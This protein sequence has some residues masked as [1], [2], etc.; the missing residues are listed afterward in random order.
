MLIK[1]EIP[2]VKIEDTKCDVT[3]E[4][5]TFSYKEFAL[6]FKFRLPVNDKSIKY[7]VARVLELVIEKEKANDYWPHL[8]SKADKKKY[9]VMYGF[10]DNFVL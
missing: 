7:K 3:K 4:G 1:I 2:D 5:L 9:K 10:S 6:E 8:L